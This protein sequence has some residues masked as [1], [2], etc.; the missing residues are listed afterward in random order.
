MN[1]HST[2]SAVETES[3][4]SEV[5][6]GSTVPV[7]LDDNN[8]FRSTLL[9]LVTYFQGHGE[10]GYYAKEGVPD[11]VLGTWVQAPSPGAMT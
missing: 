8:A 10:G 6:I 7:L 1:N 9:F 2:S 4:A 5:L 11:R 3:K